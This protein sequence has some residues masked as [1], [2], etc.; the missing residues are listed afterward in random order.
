MEK[1]R[2]KA[3]GKCRINCCSTGRKER[4]DGGGE[5]GIVAREEESQDGNAE[6]YNCSAKNAR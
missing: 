5:T 6:V 1:K 4:P 2:R 3:I